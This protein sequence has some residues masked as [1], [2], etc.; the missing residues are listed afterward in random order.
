MVSA[1]AERSLGWGMIFIRD[2]QR[3]LDL[4]KDRTLRPRDSTVLLALIANADWKTGE[5]HASQ[6]ELAEQVAMQRTAICSS[7]KRLS[8]NHLVR[9]IR[10]ERGLSWYYAI[11]P[12]VVRFGTEKAQGMIWKQFSEA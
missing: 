12:Y 1:V 11:N 5:I 10:A 6:E 8:D 2:V 4:S 9:R 3:I 7:I